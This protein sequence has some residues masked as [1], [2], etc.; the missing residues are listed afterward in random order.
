MTGEPRSDSKPLGEIT[1]FQKYSGPLSKRIFQHGDK[2]I[3]DS[4]S[5]RM[6]SGMAYRVP[7]Y[8]VKA[9]AALIN[10]FKPNE[11]Y[12]LGR[13]K[14]GLPGSVRVVR[15]DQ[16][17]GSA[18]PGVIARS[19]QFLT[20]KEGEGGFILFDLDLK[21]MP[22]AVRHRIKECG[23]LWDALCAVLPALKSV[24]RVRRAST[25]SGLWNANTG[26]KVT[27]S[28]GW[29]IVVPLLDAADIPRFLADLH[30]RLWLHGFGW[31][32]V[33]AAGSFLE[34]SIIDKS[35]GKPEHLIFEAA[36]VLMPPLKQTD[37]KAVAHDGSILD[38]RLCQPLTDAEKAELHKLKAAEENR[39]LPE[40][41]RAEWSVRH[42]KRMTAEGKTE[43]E[44][45]LLIARPAPERPVSGGIVVGHGS[46]KD[47][48]VDQNPNAPA[49]GR[50]PLHDPPEP[51]PNDPP[52][53]PLHDPP[54]DPTYEP[55]QPRTDPTP[56]PAS[57]PP[58]ELPNGL[59]WC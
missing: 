18:D 54:G 41:A 26:E 58:R 13:L 49:P 48:F 56:N 14:D 16:L 7:I 25:S 4:S 8:D 35:V 51:P 34:C 46:K 52:T 53:E 59:A 43:A 6:A 10:E 45:R 32:K 15:K 30:D 50:D 42:I 44:A 21:G 27:G 31:G 3:V 39:L 11:A 57:D 20:F 12:A 19:R 33:S 1:V 23:G 17:N 55:P 28:G 5:C 9:L 47:V 36:A 29:H 2:L 38:T 24:A 22:K 40:Q 37:R